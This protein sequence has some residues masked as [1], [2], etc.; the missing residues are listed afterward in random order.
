[1]RVYKL[2][3]P[4]EEI[5]STMKRE[6]NESRKPGVHQRLK[7][8]TAK[9]SEGNLAFYFFARGHPSSP[10]SN[11]FISMPQ[12]KGWAEPPRKLC[13]H[14]IVAWY[15]SAAMFLWHLP[16]AVVS[17][18]WPMSW[19]LPHRL[20]RWFPRQQR[21]RCIAHMGVYAMSTAFNHDPSCIYMNILFEKS[22]I[23]IHRLV[24]SRRSMLV[25]LA[26][27]ACHLEPL[28]WDVGFHF[29]YLLAFSIS[30]RGIADFI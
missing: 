29:R 7:D 11:V 16:T 2:G 3:V 17:S 12:E 9:W 19:T 23:E 20:D 22:M 18:S 24:W 27:S 15:I 4:L 5:I 1:M 6:N 30:G 26:R 10:Q 8:I 28:H 25:L 21:R 14:G 13:A